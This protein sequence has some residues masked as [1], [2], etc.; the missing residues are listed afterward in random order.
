M[1]NGVAE[2]DASDS[3]DTNCDFLSNSYIILQISHA[4]SQKLAIIGHCLS[5]LKEFIH[6]ND[7]K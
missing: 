2:G 7:W 3:H 1:K 4:N 6:K 5:S